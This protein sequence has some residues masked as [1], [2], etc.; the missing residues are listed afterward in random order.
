MHSALGQHVAAVASCLKGSLELWQ[1]CPAAWEA[2]GLQPDSALRAARR[3][4]TLATHILP[5]CLASTTELHPA[6]HNSWLTGIAEVSLPQGILVYS[7]LQDYQS[8]QRSPLTMISTA[9]LPAHKLCT[10]QASLRTEPQGSAGSCSAG[11]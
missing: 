10:P 5:Y 2:A 9:R 7:R 1:V 6:F 3:L 8:S 11:S 4:H